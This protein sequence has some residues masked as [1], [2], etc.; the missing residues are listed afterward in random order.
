MKMGGNHTHR[1]EF[2]FADVQGKPCF[3]L[4][5]TAGRIHYHA[6]TCGITEDIGIYTKRIN[7]NRLIFFAIR[8]LKLRA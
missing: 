5:V 6:F 2:V 3:F 4:L 8:I 1:L 7:T